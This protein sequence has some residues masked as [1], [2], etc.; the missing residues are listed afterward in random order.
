MALSVAHPDKDSNGLKLYNPAPHLSLHFQPVLPLCV[1][2]YDCKPAPY[3]GIFHLT[4]GK[5]AHENIFL[6]YHK[7]Q[8][9]WQT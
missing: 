7:G 9:Q 5:P 2:L 4:G 1:L 3:H 8:Y 6:Q